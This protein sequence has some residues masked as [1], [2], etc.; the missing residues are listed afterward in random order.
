ML[1]YQIDN[2]SKSASI[3][4]SHIC[5]TEIRKRLNSIKEVTGCGT[6]PYLYD[7]QFSDKVPD[8]F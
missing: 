3:Y 8:K 2:S 1:L 6:K 4:L 7:K 5:Q